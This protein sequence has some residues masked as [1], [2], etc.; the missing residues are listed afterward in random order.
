[1]L[2]GR[3]R[4]NSANIVGHVE[5][6]VEDA[7]KTNVEGRSFMTLVVAMQMMKLLMNQWV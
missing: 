3:Q 2:E 6:G 4:S 1:L 5:V 7:Y